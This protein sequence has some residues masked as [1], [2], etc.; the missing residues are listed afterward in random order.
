MKLKLRIVGLLIAV[1]MPSMCQPQRKADV[2][3]YERPAPG[4]GMTFSEKARRGWP[5]RWG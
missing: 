5:T 2:Q 1:A 3:R 4:E